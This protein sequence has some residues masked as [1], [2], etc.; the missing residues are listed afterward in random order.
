MRAG[1]VGIDAS[2]LRAIELQVAYADGNGMNV[3]S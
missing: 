2:A 3:G 1:D